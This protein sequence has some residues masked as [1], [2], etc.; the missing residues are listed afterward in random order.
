MIYV[1][2]IF[3]QLWKNWLTVMKYNPEQDRIGLNSKIVMSEQ[4]GTYGFAIKTKTQ[5]LR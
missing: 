1:G 3:Y 4:L 5:T 2:G